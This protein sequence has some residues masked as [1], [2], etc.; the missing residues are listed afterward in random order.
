[1]RLETRAFHLW[2]N[3]YFKDGPRA[4]GGHPSQTGIASCL[5][6]RSHAGMAVRPTICTKRA[7]QSS[8]SNFPLEFGFT[9]N[10]CDF[11]WKRQTGDRRNFNERVFRVVNQLSSGECRDSKGKDA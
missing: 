1:M 3:L 7:N 6:Q 10:L 5:G 2:T 11:V 9:F 4:A 8:G